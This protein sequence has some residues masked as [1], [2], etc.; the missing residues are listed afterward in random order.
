MC[1]I[2]GALTTR[3]NVDLRG[4]VSCIVDDQFKRGPDVQAVRD[5]RNTDFQVVLGHDRL[6]IIDL[7]PE[8][9]QPM[10]SG[11]GHLAVVF[12]GEIYNFLELRAELEGEGATFRTRS[13][14]EVILT[15]Y[16]R[17]AENAFDRFIGMFALAIYDSRAR[18]LVLVRD[19]FGVKPLYY[20]S[21]GISAAFAS[22]PGVIAK[23][24]KLSPDLAYVTR[25]IQYKYYEDESQLSPYLGVL[26]LEPSHSLRF[27]LS[28]GRL[29]I[30]KRRYYDL[31]DKTRQVA[32]TIRGESQDQLEIRLVEL[33][34]NACVLRQ[35][36][37]V[38]LG[39]SVSGGVDSSTIAAFLAEGRTRTIG[40]SFADPNRFD[41][42][43][44]LVA[45]L[46]RMTRMEPR[47]VWIEKVNEISDLFWETL[48]AQDAPFPH[49]SV[50]AQYA[51]FRAARADGTIV[52][53]GGQ[54]GDEAFMGYRKFFLF[55]AQSI[56]RERRIAEIPYFLSAIL[57]VIPAV[58]KRASV[59]AAE[60]KRYSNA[61][62]GMGSRLMLPRP[63]TSGAMGMSRS[64][65]I[66][67]RQI[68]DVTRFSLPT[69]L[70]YEDRNSM[71]NSVESRLPFMDHRVVELGLALPERLKL[72]NGFGKLILRRIMKGKVP[73]S[74]RLNRDKRGFDVN[75]QEW[76]VR[77]LGAEL[78]SA[79]QQRKAVISHLLPR[80]ASLDALFSDASLA[81]HPQAFKEAVSLIWL[82]NR[83]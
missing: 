76:I 36:S 18:E 64:H 4:L 72:G 39:L 21:D 65:T 12:N 27:R 32:E 42:E 2:A 61:N 16:E 31:S 1:G 59:F 67:E 29:A 80:G 74:I 17:W 45:E 15:A 62:L 33:L 55:Y 41:T 13:D 75:Q 66:T 26:S 83:L 14:T 79:I 7:S 47:Y 43:G 77:G 56:I 9:N 46:A 22:T 20:W 71:G 30:S 11:D 58:T 78:R 73:E 51:V 53:L 48:S 3:S 28:G 63:Q 34:Q 60:R 57:P 37:D 35:R 23:W 5:Y 52:L 81:R 44:P 68:L 24:A 70:R 49:A 19:R 25:G 69:L 10:L 6:S 50:M 54:G 40:Y 8:A 82:G 38:P